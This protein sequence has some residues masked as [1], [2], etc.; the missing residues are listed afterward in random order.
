M[1]IKKIITIGANTANPL[2]VK[3]LGY[4]TMRLPGEQVWGEPENREEAVQI[5]KAKLLKVILIFWTQLIIM[6]KM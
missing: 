2:P 5:L 3:R 1:N 4:G 6:E